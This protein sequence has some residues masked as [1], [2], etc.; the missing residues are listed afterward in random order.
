M[1]RRIP[2]FVLRIFMNWLHISKVFLV[3]QLWIVNY[4]VKCSP[5]NLCNENINTGVSG[6]WYFKNSS[7]GH[8]DS[9]L[10]LITEKKQQTENEEFFD[11]YL[12]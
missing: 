7:F 6:K 9:H 1:T 8:F 3:H 5:N 2:N 12:M 4:C 11:E 10:F